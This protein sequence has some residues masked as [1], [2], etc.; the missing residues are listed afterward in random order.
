MKKLFG[1]LAFGVLLIPPAMAQNT[2]G[3]DLS[4]GYSLRLYTLPD[5]ARVGMN[6]WYGSANYNIFRWL[7]AAAEVTGAYRNNG[8]NGNT[9]IYTAL[10]GPQ[11]YP[12]GHQHKLTIFGHILAGE[13]YYR[14]HYPAFGGFPP[15]TNSD[16]RFSWEAGGGVEMTR[17]TRWGIRLFELDYGRTHFFG[18][19]QNN[20]RLSIGFVYH[21]G[22]K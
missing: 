1:M 21:F 18:P 22:G 4:S 19:A 5:Y 9:S 16:S 13:A 14:V 20:Y 15:M 6:G 8:T 2:R 7:G 17:S 10:V 3:V 12:F 11:L